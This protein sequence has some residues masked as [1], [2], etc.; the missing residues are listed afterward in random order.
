[1]KGITLA[2]QGHIINALG[3][4]DV[5][6]GAKTSDYWNMNNYAHATIIITTGIVG[7]DCLIKLYES[8]DNAGGVQQFKSFQS[9]QETTAGGDTLGAR[10]TTASSGIQTGTNNVTTIVIEVDA[11]ELT[12]EYNYMAVLTDTA[13]A[14]LIAVTVVLTGSRHQGDPTKE[15]PT[16][17]T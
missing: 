14:C 4:V 8:K 12:A 3:P 13:A 15:S 16:A 17:I 10:T 11:S 7:N 9:Y 1:M 2:E 6:G 5:A